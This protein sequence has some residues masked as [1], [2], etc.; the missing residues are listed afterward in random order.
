MAKAEDRPGD[1]DPT[2][3]VTD[4][5]LRALLMDCLRLWG[6]EGR[7]AVGA[8]GVEI[9]TAGACFILRR[10]RADEAPMRWRLSALPETAGQRARFAPSIAAMLSALRKAVA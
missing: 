8:G 7:V 4:A 5:E 10:A 3:P 1:F 9:L 6:V 2:L